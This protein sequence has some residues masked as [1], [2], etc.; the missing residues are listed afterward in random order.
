MRSHSCI[1]IVAVLILVLAATAVVSSAENPKPRP[2]K[3]NFAGEA[4]FPASDACFDVTGVPYQTLTAT[5]GKMTHLGRTTL[6]TAHC[7]TVD[8][9]AAVGGEAT[10]TAANGDQVWAAYT[11]VTVEWPVPPLMLIVQ[12]SEFTIVGG[13]GRFEGASGR[14]LGLVYVT[15]EGFDDPSWPI[16][17]VFAGTIAY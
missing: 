10:F 11:A 14:L 4:S 7:S 17:L 5:E 8:G 12:E 13:T 16:E 6:S 15:F 3:G 1:R 9:S 2:F